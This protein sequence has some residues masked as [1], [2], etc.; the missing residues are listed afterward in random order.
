MTSTEIVLRGR[1]DNELQQV[2]T[3]NDAIRFFQSL[4]IEDLNFDHPPVTAGANPWQEIT[5]ESAQII[6]TAGLFRVF[7]IEV[8]RL[9][10]TTERQIVREI[11]KSQMKDGWAL[12]GKYLLVFGAPSSDVWHLVTPYEEQRTLSSGRPVLRRYTL[13]EGETHRTV[14]NALSNMD[15]SKGRLAERI[16]E[17][18]RVKPVTEDFYENYKSAFDTLSKELRRK[19]LEIED[20]DRYAHTTL[21]RLMFFYYLQKKGWI[22]DRKDFVRWFH[23]RYEESNEEDAFHEK[24][25]SALFFEGMNSPEG[26]EVDADLPSDVESAIVGLPY[27]NGGLFQ[28]TEDDESGT[29]L[30]DSALNSIIKEFLEHYNF[31]VTEESPYDIDVAVDPA[32]LGKIYESLIAE[33]DRGESGIFYTPRTEVDLMCRYSIYEHLLKVA[34]VSS[35][36]GRDQIVDF[37][38]SEPNNWEGESGKTSTLESCLHNLVIVDP[39]CGSGAFLVGMVQVLEELYRKLGVNLE[40]EAKKKMINSNIY[41]VD[42]KDWAVRVAEFRLWLSLV[43]SADSLPDERPVLPNFSFNLQTGDSIIQ[44]VGEQRISVKSLTQSPSKEVQ[45]ALQKVEDLKNE[46][47]E[48][49]RDDEAEIKKQQAELLKQHIDEIIRRK[50]SGEQE[51][52]GGNVRKSDSDRQAQLEI[53]RLESIKD[54]LDA[55]GGDAFFLWELDFAEVILNGGFDVVIGNPPY[56]RSESIT[57]PSLSQ[58]RLNHMSDEVQDEI[59]QKYKS[60]LNKFVMETYNFEP[61]GK[62]DYYSFFFYKGL[63]V[64]QPEGVLC[65]ITSDK[66][67]DRRYGSDLQEIFLTSSKL[68]SIIASRTEQTFAEAEITTAI[69]TV[70]KQ[71]LDSHDLR[72]TPRFISC[73]KPYGQ[74]F[75]T[76]NIPSLLYVECQEEA[77]YRG[78]SFKLATKDHAR[79]ISIEATSLWRLG[80]GQINRNN[81]DDSN[82]VSPQGNYSGDKWGSMYLRAPNII[83]EILEKHGKRIETLDNYEVSS[84]L[85]TGGAKNFYIIER[86][87]D[88]GKGLSHI[89]NQEFDQSFTVEDRFLKP[90]L[91]SPKDTN[92]LRINQKDTGAIKI[93]YVPPET[94]VTDY[95]VKEYI[96]FGEEKK[97]NERSGPSRREPWWKPPPNAATGSSIV[98]PRTHDNNHRAFYNP[99]KI[100]TG[101]FYRTDP[102]HGEFISLILNSTFVSLFIEIYGDPR[103]QGALDLFTDDYGKLPIFHP[104][105]KFINIPDSAKSML[106][107][108]P[109]SVFEE[110]GAESSQNVTLA[111]V[112]QDRRALD[113]FVMGEVMGLTDNAQLDIYRGLLRLVNE[114]LTK[115]NKM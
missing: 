97:Y 28:P 98:L 74:I 9:S 80:G 52:L 70:E 114:R 54:R 29:F 112:K 47:F 115:A 43:E 104:N 20:A 41:G 85:N 6:A 5:V 94:K 50:D 68:K 30:S 102:D 106:D 60:Q 37:V 1:L 83:Y 77:N 111:S 75:T 108:K 12:E 2:S 69:T 7:Y 22:G 26:G 24:W 66:W 25:L 36:E 84:Y 18:F 31:T 40:F 16:D 86:I 14:A 48:G 34:C 96:Q 99:E 90:F 57:D 42:I 64:L 93:L 101:R 33:E 11:T 113:E 107:R 100:I 103:G 35:D 19:G 27:M 110:L 76:E 13:G 62:S 88:A 91:G 109:E 51:T 21:N 81:L 61:N 45:K 53:E 71:D 82:E 95:H 15:A 23:E 58:E 79:I 55:S 4:F 59:Q 89:S 49:I 38:F 65:Y 67:L 10:R 39:A 56:V 92:S 46:Y 78:E 32:M 17:A 72:G 8:D 87:R 44:T 3:A 63:E 73:S 105:D